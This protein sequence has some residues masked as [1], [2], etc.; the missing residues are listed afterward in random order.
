MVSFSN[1][2]VFIGVDDNG[3]GGIGVTSATFNGLP[4]TNISSTPETGA[5][6]LGLHVFLASDVSEITGDLVITTADSSPSVKILALKL[7]KIKSTV[8][9][10]TFGV[11][12]STVVPTTL[13][14][15]GLVSVEAGDLVVSAVFNRSTNNDIYPID[16]HNTLIPRF[17][18]SG[19]SSLLTATRATA[20]H[21]STT[22]QFRISG[23][24]ATTRVATI[25]LTKDSS[26]DPISGRSLS[27]KVALERFFDDA[28]PD[29]G[30]GIVVG[31]VTSSTTIT[32]DFT[33][34][35]EDDVLFI[36]H[37]PNA[38]VYTIAAAGPTS[39]T[40]VGLFPTPS[41]TNVEFKAGRP[42]FVA[43]DALSKAFT[44]LKNVEIAIVSAGRLLLLHH[45][46][47]IVYRNGTASVGL[48]G[49]PDSLFTESGG[50]LVSSGAYARG[51]P[52]STVRQASLDVRSATT[53]QSNL[54]GILSSG[55][56]YDGR[57][58][59]IDERINLETGILAK[60]TRAVENRQKALEKIVASLTKLLTL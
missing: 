41:E 24:S 32:G 18:G 8:S 56:L 10:T 15:S 54:E 25:I 50:R 53:D 22:S 39:A 11:A 38:G 14:A 3:S 5:S 44:A 16:G 23:S 12:S 46:P 20:A 34:V 47:I 36:R 43:M 51:I 58:V 52:N 6:N 27:E 19:I 26:A 48:P 2:L 13:G 28:M 42:A 57:F 29:R 17:R 60:R 33:N 59:W 49:T 1:L 4:M 31:S 45:C 30:L 55:H 7:S 35:A 21:Q 40:V 9:A 37:G